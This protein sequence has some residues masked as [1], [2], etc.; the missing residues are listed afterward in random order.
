MKG[1][2]FMDLYIYSFVPGM[3]IET[4]SVLWE[5][6][7]GNSVVNERSRFPAPVELT[8]SGRGGERE[9]AESDKISREKYYSVVKDQLGDWSKK[10]AFQLR[11]E[12]HEGTSPGE[13]VEEEHCRYRKNNTRRP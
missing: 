6:C 8:F 13:H 2:A 10:V 9:G 3:F 7:R 12:C 11:R 4:L 5:L 1:N